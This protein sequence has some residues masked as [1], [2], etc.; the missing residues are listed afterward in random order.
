MTVFSQNASV[1]CP[2]PYQAQDLGYQQ[3]TMTAS[4]VAPTIPQDARRALVTV[5]GSATDTVR[6]R[7]DATAPTASVGNPIPVVVLPAQTWPP[8]VLDCDFTNLKFIGASTSK[9]NITFQR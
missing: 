4:A 2:A 1:V 9:V 3:L 6:W 7:A 5:E 8:L